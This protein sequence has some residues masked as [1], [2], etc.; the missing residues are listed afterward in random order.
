LTY[1]RYLVDSRWMTNAIGS[2]EVLVTGPGSKVS[3]P[4]WVRKYAP[5]VALAAEIGDLDE[6]SSVTV[7]Q[8]EAP[9]A[10][11]EHEP[12]LEILASKHRETGRPSKI[13]F[14]FQKRGPSAN[15]EKLE[16]VLRHFG[17][18]MDIE[19]ASGARNAAFAMEEAFAKI[20]VE[21]PR[22]AFAG[23]RRDALGEIRSIV[24][25]TADLRS[26]SGRLSAQR[27]AAAFGLPL[28]E[29]SD[30]IGRKRQTTW[31]TRDAE[32][33][34]QVLLP[35]ER[36]ARLRAVLSPSDFR[37]WLNLPNDQL[38][39]RSPLKVIRSGDVAVVADLTEDMLSGTSG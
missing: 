13:L 23:P 18:A 6:L 10:V 12:F 29:L 33:L 8:A 38:D 30:L 5:K 17:S 35:F 32:S 14:V 36:I 16:Q 7:V 4:V 3:V 1:G 21:S 15:A 22:S 2:L 19:F 9:D 26:T 31:K 37:R 11:L 25:A 20:R 27:V 28:A 24:A 34:Q 39:Q